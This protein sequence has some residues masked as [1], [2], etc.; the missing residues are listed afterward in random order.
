MEEIEVVLDNEHHYSDARDERVKETGEIFT[1]LPLI[2]KMLDEIGYDWDNHDHSKTWLDPTGGSGNFLVALAQRGIL[3]KNLYSAELMQDNVDLCKERLEGP[4]P[5]EEIKKILNKNIV[6]NDFLTYDC[7]F[8][9]PKETEK[10][11][12]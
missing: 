8:E 12:F 3:L 2:N 10:W 11:N 6:C 9:E 7:S 1:P 4:N 5:T